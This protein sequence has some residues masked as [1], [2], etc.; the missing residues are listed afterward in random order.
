M[1]IRKSLN[2]EDTKTTKSPFLCASRA[3]KISWG[4]RVCVVQAFLV[5]ALA[6]NAA[7][8][9]V[10]GGTL[11]LVQSNEPPGLVSAL[12]ASTY[13]GTVSTK[14]MEG[15][16]EYDLEQKPKPSLAESWEVSPDG[17]AYTFHLRHGVAWHDGK[18]FTSADVKFSLLK[19][20][21]VLHPRGRVTFGTVTD[22]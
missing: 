21:K 8:Q 15:L 18:P 6:A 19:I 12:N 16:L 1:S 7:A 5:A 9:P 22:V 3:G 20:W 4:L 13:I 2:H 14:I 11:T 17:L 10:P